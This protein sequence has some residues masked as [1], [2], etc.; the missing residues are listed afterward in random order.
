M[1][2]TIQITTSAFLASFAGLNL[3]V[4]LF[5]RPLSRGVVVFF[6]IGQILSPQSGT[7]EQAKAMGFEGT[8]ADRQ[9]PIDRAKAAKLLLLVGTINFLGCVALYFLF[10]KTESNSVPTPETIRSEGHDGKQA[11]PAD[12]NRISD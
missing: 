2:A 7:R 9:F 10:P 12:G 8:F 4:A 5:H 11:A 3:L 6:N 1:T